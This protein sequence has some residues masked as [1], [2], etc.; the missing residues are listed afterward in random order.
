MPTPSSK[1]DLA[2]DAASDLVMALSA[3]DGEQ[4]ILVERFIAD[5]AGLHDPAILDEFLTLRADPTLGSI[6]QIA[7]AISGEGREQL[8][9]TAEEIYSAESLRN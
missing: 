8:L 5:M 4:L 9:F 3:L 2:R 7:A 1:P 6:L